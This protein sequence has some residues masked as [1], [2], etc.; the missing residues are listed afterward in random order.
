MEEEILQAAEVLN[1]IM[2]KKPIVD[3]SFEHQDIICEDKIK[4]FLHP[5]LPICVLC[6]KLVWIMTFIYSISI[7]MCEQELWVMVLT[8]QTGLLEC[9]DLTPAIEND[10][11]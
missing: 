9:P 1:Q 6:G 2:E 7:K 10:A 3:L 8:K 11:D 5:L 4:K